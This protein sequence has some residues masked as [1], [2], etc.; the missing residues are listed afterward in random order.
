L[1]VKEEENIIKVLMVADN[2]S[3]G[4]KERRMIEL[5]RYFDNLNRIKVCLVILKDIIEYSEVFNLKNTILFVFPR[6]FK[7]DPLIYFKL[8]KLCRSFSPDVIHSW[9]SMTSVYMS[10]IAFFNKIPFINAMIVS[11]NC[12]RLSTN[13]LRAKISFPFST[14]IL[15]NSYAGL[16]AYGVISK[17]G[18]VIHNGFNFDRILSLPKSQIMRDEY[19][20]HTKY[21]IG[22]IGALHWRKDYKTYLEVAKEICNQRNDVSFLAIGDGPDKLP[23]MFEYK[24]IKNIIFTGNIKQ[25]EKLIQIFDIGVLLSPEGLFEGISNAV[26]EMMAMSKPVIATSGGGTNEIIH[27]NQTGYL[28]KANSK[29]ELLRYL[30]DLLENPDKRLEFGKNAKLQI[31]SEFGIE[32]MSKETI[33]LYESLL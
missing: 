18:I 9:G 28:I 12:N 4:G 33:Q 7:K 20:I 24:D 27:H 23:Y 19:N 8:W 25:V 14:V 30:H 3:R 2:L 13:W 10:T 15:A 16:K 17:K 31:E 5:L 32:K 21:V 6:R 11:S 22:M 1:I 29:E 26:L